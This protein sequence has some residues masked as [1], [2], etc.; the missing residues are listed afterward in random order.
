MGTAGVR[1]GWLKVMY[2]YTIIGGGGGGL[3]IIF[4]PEFVKSVTGWTGHSW[5]MLGLA[6]SVYLAFGITSVFAL[7]A[8]LKFAPVLVLQLLYKSI[9]LVGVMLPQLIRGY[10]PTYGI[11][12]AVVF[13]TYIIGDLIAIPFRVVFANESKA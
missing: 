13:L 6:G 9:W 8:P 11:I 2:V 1:L 3:A 4:A 10:M 12:T 7:R 5:M